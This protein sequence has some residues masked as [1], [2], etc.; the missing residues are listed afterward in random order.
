MDKE[1]LRELVWKEMDERGVATF[2]RPA[3]GRIPNFVGS[4]K[5]AARLRELEVY[6]RAEVIMVNPD[7]AQRAVRKFA[8]MDGKKLLMATPRLAEGFILL[9]P[10]EVGDPER[11]SG[12]RGAFEHGI[13]ADL[14]G[15][16]VD[17]IVEGSVAVDVYGGRVG[18]GSGWGDLEY[19]ILRELGA[20]GEDVMV[21]TTVHDIQILDLQIPMTFHDVPVDI[22]V[23]PTR[24]IYTQTPHPRPKGIFWEKLDESKLKLPVIQKIKNRGFNFK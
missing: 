1:E 8:L 23:T 16:K 24:F 15:L 22:I 21:A 10:I 3:R 12:I 7:S 4:E 17:L 11:A 5:A 13:P 6:K 2:P 14:S 9:D 18:K 19:A 20:A